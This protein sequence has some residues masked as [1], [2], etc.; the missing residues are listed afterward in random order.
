MNQNK[1][2]SRDLEGFCT[3]G[4]V[5]IG[6]RLLAIIYCASIRT[7]DNEILSIT[8]ICY[9]LYLLWGLQGNTIHRTTILLISHSEGILFRACL[10][11]R[12]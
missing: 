4:V 9:L 6:I 8:L 2:L 11:S 10:T 3:K 1:V 12:F 5:A 7:N